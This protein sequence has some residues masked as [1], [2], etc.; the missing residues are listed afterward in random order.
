MIFIE[1]ESGSVGNTQIVEMMIQY[2]MI[3]MIVY[4][5]GALIACVALR[6]LLVGCC[7]LL[8][9]RISVVLVESRIEN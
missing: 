1:D 8:A 4:D 3:V 2:S 9:I 6:W 7:W 5:G